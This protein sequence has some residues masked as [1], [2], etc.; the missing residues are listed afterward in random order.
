[1]SRRSLGTSENETGATEF[2]MR[3]YAM[4]LCL[5]AAS[6]IVSAAAVAQVAD[7]TAH[8]TAY[9]TYNQTQAANPTEVFWT[10]AV[11]NDRWIISAWVEMGAGVCTYHFSTLDKQTSLQSAPLQVG[12]NGDNALY[13]GTV[14]SAR[15]YRPAICFTFDPTTPAN[16]G[17][18]I[19]VPMLSPSNAMD[20]WL[21][22]L[23]IDPTTT[24]NP[25]PTWEVNPDRDPVNVSN[26]NGN[27]LGA[28]IAG[29]VNGEIIVAWRDDTQ[30]GPIGDVTGITPIGPNPNPSNLTVADIYARRFDQLFPA[31]GVPGPGASDPIAPGSTLNI[32][33]CRSAVWWPDVVAGSSDTAYVGFMVQGSLVDNVANLGA[34]S[35]PLGGTFGG[36]TND[37][38]LVSVR[39]T[40]TSG[41]VRVGAINVSSSSGLDNAVFHPQLAYN[42]I[43]NQIGVVWQDLTNSGGIGGNPNLAATDTGIFP[44]PQQYDV[45]L[46]TFNTSLNNVGV[47]KISATSARE[48][49]VA[50]AGT[51][52]AGWVVG[53]TEVVS[54]TD[55]RARQRAYDGNLVNQGGEQFY[56]VQSVTVGGPPPAVSM[57]KM[58]SNGTT[59]ITTAFSQG[60]NPDNLRVGQPAAATNVIDQFLAHGQLVSTTPTTGQLAVVG[61]QVNNGNL[62]NGQALPT[63]ITGSLSLRNNS[64]V[65]SMQ[66]TSLVITPPQGW[67]IQGSGIVLPMT[68]P[69]GTSN[70]IEYVFVPQAAQVQAGVNTWGAAASA[71]LGANT[72][73]AAASTQFSVTGMVGDLS[74]VQ[75]TFALNPSTITNGSSN[76]VTVNV[77]ISNSGADPLSNIAI[78]GVL[79]GGITPGTLN[80][81]VWTPSLNGLLISSGGVQVLSTT[82]TAGA[83]LPAGSYLPGFHLSADQ[84]VRSG[85]VTSGPTNPL[86]VNSGGGG[87][88]GGGGGL[89][90][91]DRGSNCSVVSGSSGIGAL[92]LLGLLGLLA[93]RRRVTVR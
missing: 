3:K 75:F 4:F 5:L 66:V 67:S 56:P 53:W 74:G 8:G 88:G 27:S 59:S 80:S 25:S 68:L 12:G 43:L 69:P 45:F 90:T 19:A 70:P 24:T 2:E 79:P 86:T 39:A 35:G 44:N 48:F 33:Q 26:S 83:S 64:P 23:R 49:M 87:G 22:F 76:Q 61:F 29:L 41:L 31:P 55:H 32:S 17:V 30:A 46:R 91:V 42:R 28:A 11:E 7:Y 71:T 77:T 82:L 58:T 93:W 20:I 62:L 18:A 1:M 73:S 36:E 85:T 92:V 37:A 47:V 81:A 10:N 34:N 9:G 72:L 15:A 60:G 84:G 52:A 16:N 6:L 78:T 50:V 40:A 14:Y 38:Y 21:H 57:W 65:D 51:G 54:A 13:T 89:V 63:Q